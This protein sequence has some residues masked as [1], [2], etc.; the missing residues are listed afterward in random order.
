[1]PCTPS[2]H[3]FQATDET[4]TSFSC[5]IDCLG[6]SWSPLRAM[7][8][9]LRGD[10]GAGRE[11]ETLADYLF[12]DSL[13]DIACALL[14]LCP[15]HLPRQGEAVRVFQLVLAPPESPEVILPGAAVFTSVEHAQCVVECTPDVM[16]QLLETE[17][18][19]DEMVTVGKPGHFIYIPRS[20]LM[21][22]ERHMRD[23]LRAKRQR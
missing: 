22:Y 17:V 18:Y 16:W 1:M 11:F 15:R 8:V 5:G 9:R 23:T 20:V 14:G 10:I 6:D 21:G 7:A 2:S 4:A 12:D 3:N 19:P 13:R